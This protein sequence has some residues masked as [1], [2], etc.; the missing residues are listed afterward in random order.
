[1]EESQNSDNSQAKGS[2]YTDK[3]QG[4]GSKN[5]K[6][7]NN[8]NQNEVSNKVHENPV[9]LP[10]GYHK[11]LVKAYREAIK[12][13]NNSPLLENLWNNAKQGKPNQLPTPKLKI[14]FSNNMPNQAMKFRKM[15]KPK[16]L[17]GLKADEKSDR[18]HH[19]V[20]KY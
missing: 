6:S 7:P 19:I 12:R 8:S 14:A 18:Q 20:W 4:K 13:I 10:L 17:Y 2:K 5:I 9:W 1:M 16:K 15:Y 3:S 11:D